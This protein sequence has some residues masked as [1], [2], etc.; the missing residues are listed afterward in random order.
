LAP[1]LLLWDTVVAALTVSYSA[2]YTVHS[3]TFSLPALPCCRCWQ[4]MV[5]LS[6]VVVVID[7]LFVTLS[8]VIVVL[9]LAFIVAIIVHF[10]KCDIDESC[11]K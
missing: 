11:T 1:L 10:V 6:L 8:L 9:D 4:L 3:L 5:D 2:A 7:Q